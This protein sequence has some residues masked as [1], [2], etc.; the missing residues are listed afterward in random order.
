MIS[1][2]IGKRYL[3]K[4][5]LEAFLARGVEIEAMFYCSEKV[6]PKTKWPSKSCMAAMPICA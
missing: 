2:F 4:A 5:A 3:G 6:G 1:A